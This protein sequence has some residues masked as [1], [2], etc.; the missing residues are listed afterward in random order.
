MRVVYLHN[1]NFDGENQ[2]SPLVCILRSCPNLKELIFLLG[3]RKKSGMKLDVNLL[4]GPGSGCNNLQ[5]L[6]IKKFH[7]STTELWFVKFIL[8]FAPLLRKAILL[9]ERSVGERQFSKISNKL[10]QLPR[11]SPNSEII[12]KQY[13]SVKQARH[14]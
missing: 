11:A 1:Y 8:V 12:Y 6:Q 13:C 2:I 7:G 10:K 5:I 14:G 4:E 9:V 3:K